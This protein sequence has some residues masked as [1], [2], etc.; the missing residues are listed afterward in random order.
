M[1]ECQCGFWKN[2]LIEETITRIEIAED[3]DKIINKIILAIIL[4]ADDPYS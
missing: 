4:A 2:R 1:V 3:I